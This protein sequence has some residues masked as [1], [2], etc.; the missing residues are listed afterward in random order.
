MVVLHEIQCCDEFIIV[1][2]NLRYDMYTLSQIYFSIFRNHIARLYHKRLDAYVMGLGPGFS[3]LMSQVEK[4]DHMIPC[5]FIMTIVF[6][7]R[8]M[9]HMRKVQI[10]GRVHMAGFEEMV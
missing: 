5:V 4:I 8:Q 2:G 3:A 10:H 1:N 6:H 7:I 9:E